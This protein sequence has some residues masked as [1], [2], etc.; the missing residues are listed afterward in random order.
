MARTDRELI[1]LG[2]KCVIKLA[3]LN[4]DCWECSANPKNP[5]CDWCA[6]K[7]NSLWGGGLK[8]IDELSDKEI[9]KLYDEVEE[10]ETE[11]N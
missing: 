3:Y 10:Y 1:I 7:N 4:I 2:K 6:S 9:E 11:G 5:I 8:E